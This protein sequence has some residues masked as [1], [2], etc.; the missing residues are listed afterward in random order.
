MRRLLAPPPFGAVLR[1]GGFDC[2]GLELLE[3]CCRVGRPI[4]R[5]L[6]ETRE[7][8]ALERFGDRFAR[9]RRRCGRLR[10]HVLDDQLDLFVA[11]RR[12][13]TI[14]IAPETNTMIATPTRSSRSARCG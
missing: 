7:H 3:K 12:R 14:H 6:F 8:E 10:V 4:L 2:A 9:E 5:R 11:Q 1:P 13:T